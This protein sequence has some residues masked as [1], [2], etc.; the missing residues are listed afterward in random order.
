MYPPLLPWLPWP[1]ILELVTVV[2]A[3]IGPK[4]L[5][6]LHEYALK[7]WTERG[8]NQAEIN[9]HKFLVLTWFLV[10]NYHVMAFCLKSRVFCWKTGYWEWI[11]DNDI[12]HLPSC[13]SISCLDDVMVLCWCL[14]YCCD[15]STWQRQ[16]I[17][18]KMCFRSWFQRVWV[19]LSEE[20]M[21]I[22]CI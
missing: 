1:Y 13:G 7:C 20:C 19:Y 14:L 9:E 17:R 8:W 11:I 3:G 21:G 18:E 10:H 5:L 22:S 16:C 12:L 6:R 2:M 4:S 15:R